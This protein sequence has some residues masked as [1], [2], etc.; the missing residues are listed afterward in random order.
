MTVHAYIANMPNLIDCSSS[1]KDDYFTHLFE[2]N[3][4]DGDAHD[5][6]KSLAKPPRNENENLVEIGN[7]GSNLNGD[8]EN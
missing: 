5:D 8:N 6:R 2:A 7:G 3:S 1:D 4:D